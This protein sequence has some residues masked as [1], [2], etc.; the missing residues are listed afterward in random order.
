MMSGGPTG[1]VALGLAG[2]CHNDIGGAGAH[3]TCVDAQ[4]GPFSLFG[5]RSQHRG[6]DS[7]PFA[8]FISLLCMVE[9]RV[10]PGRVLVKLGSADC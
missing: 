3:A 1:R 4:P 9:S 5:D 7:I 6:R 2:F 10:E 8:P